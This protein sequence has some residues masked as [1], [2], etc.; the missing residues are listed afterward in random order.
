MGSDTNKSREDMCSEAKMQGDEKSQVE[1][2]KEKLVLKSVNGMAVSEGSRMDLQNLANSKQWAKSLSASSKGSKNTRPGYWSKPNYVGYR[3]R[4]EGLEDLTLFRIDKAQSTRA[5]WAKQD[6]SVEKLTEG[7][8]NPKRSLAGQI[9]W[10]IRKN[11]REK[12]EASSENDWEI[13]E[14]IQSCEGSKASGPDGF[15]LNFFKNQWK[16]VKD[17]VMCLVED[18]YRSEC[19]EGCA[20]TSFITLVSKRA[21]PSNIGEYRPISLMGS[22]YKIIAQALANRLKMV[23]EEIVGEN[24]FAFIKGRQLLDC[25]LITNEVIDVLKKNREGGFVFKVDFEKAYD[26]M[27]WSFLS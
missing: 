3:R 5:D 16:V 1:R 25:S 7:P 26:T 22:P 11:I 14:T 23:L 20:N 6:L 15:N 24:Q 13:W 4:V 12:L 10:N 27:E 9:R 2:L 17:D 19:M 8:T 21:N 18:F